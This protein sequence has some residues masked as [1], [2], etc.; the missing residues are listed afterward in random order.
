MYFKTPIMGEFDHSNLLEWSFFL[1][2]GEKKVD[3]YVGYPII[4]YITHKKRAV[5]NDTAL[6]YRKNI[7]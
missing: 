1:P 3:N 5:S 7:Y 2:I 6:F 4:E